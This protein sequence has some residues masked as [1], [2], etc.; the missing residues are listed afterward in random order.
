MA[1]GVRGPGKEQM[2]NATPRDA[3]GIARR[4]SIIVW[5]TIAIVIGVVLLVW[6][7]QAALNILLVFFV[8]I[9]FA[10]AIRPLVMCLQRWLIP[11]WLATLLV[12][13]LV[14]AVVGS[15]VYLLVR[16]LVAQLITFSSQVPGY[17][18]Q[19]EQFLSQSHD[20]NQ[21]FPFLGTNLGRQ[22]SDNIGAELQKLT[23]QIVQWVLGVPQALFTIIFDTVVTL[24]LA[25][26]WLNATDGLHAFTVSLFPE[27]AQPVADG[28]IREIGY[29]LGGYV[30]GVVTNMFVIGV[31]A[32]LADLVLGI[33]Y[34]LL[35]GIFAGLMEAVPIVGPYLSAVPAVLLALTI[36]PLKMVEVIIAYIVVQVFENNTLVPLVM[37]RAVGVN[38]LLTLL[39][40]LIGGT[41]FGIPGAL[42]AVPVTSVLQTLFLRVLVPL[43]RSGH[44]TAVSFPEKKDEH[45]MPPSDTLPIQAAPDQSVA[46]E[47]QAV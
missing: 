43:V 35:L 6:F 20:L 24:F 22:L 9:I 25:F 36:G 16:P 38:P 29:R 39:A 12:Y 3:V 10:E 2:P 11:R 4:T 15:L 32:G 8:A 28:L 45:H 47:E 26:Y 33:P 30:R 44:I 23:S 7:V 17:I 5:T 41:I 19:I 40:V 13:L 34:P 21:Y 37:D 42:L 46:H 1:R 18:A 31:M 27:S 14:F